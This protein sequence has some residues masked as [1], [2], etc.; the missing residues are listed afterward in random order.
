MATSGSTD[1]SLNARQI[2]TY[3]LG[4]LAVID[5]ISGPS[6]EDIET[7]KE[8]LNVMLKSW[9]ADVP[10][11]WRETEGSTALVAATASYSITAAYKISSVRYRNAS[12]YDLEMQEL[13]RDEYYSLP[14]KSAAGAPHSY[15]V[16]RQRAGI[17]IYI[18]GVPASVTT[19]T[20]KYTYQRRFEDIDSLTDDLDLPAERLAL[21]GYWLALFMAPEFGAGVDARRLSSIESMAMMLMQQAK[22]DGRES[23]Y[24]FEPVRR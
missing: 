3:A 24:R 1:F 4:K 21:V 10:S 17:T 9:Q 16:D 19:E 15:Y 23:V 14:N 6:A 8:N 7:G 2:I 5:P 12:G 11:L 22:A 20:I 18:Y 13:T